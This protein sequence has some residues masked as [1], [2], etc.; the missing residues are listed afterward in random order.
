[1]P[2]TYGKILHRVRI[3]LPCPR[4]FTPSFL[5][6]SAFFVIRLPTFRCRPSYQKPIVCAFCTHRP[7]GYFRV[8]LHENI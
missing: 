1:M 6:A 3:A 2:Y 5:N 4:H 8:V 7:S